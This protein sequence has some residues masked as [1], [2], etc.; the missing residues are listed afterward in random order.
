MARS[1]PPLAETIVPR[2]SEASVLQKVCTEEGMDPTA[3]I[4]S[5]PRTIQTIVNDLSK[6]RDTHRDQG[7]QV[8]IV[9]IFK[10]SYETS[11]EAVLTVE[12]A[13]KRD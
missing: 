1:V 8:D 12:T 4:N 2:L 11:I 3:C 9:E 10:N 6:M 7:L 5:S 13:L